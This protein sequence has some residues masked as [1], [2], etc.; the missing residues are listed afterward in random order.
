MGLIGMID[1]CG[2]RILCQPIKEEVMTE[3]RSF[4]T[5]PSQYPHSDNSKSDR[6]SSSEGK[7]KLRR[8]LP[9]NQNHLPRRHPRRHY[10][11]TT[12]IVVFHHNLL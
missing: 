3:G 12:E 6:H 9:N 8:T 11:A 2:R 10:G 7:K 5:N 1:L 4:H